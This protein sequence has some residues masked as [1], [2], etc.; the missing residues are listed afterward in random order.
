MRYIMEPFGLALLVEEKA[1]NT[2]GHST[3]HVLRCVSS[4]SWRTFSSSPMW[5]KCSFSG[6]DH[7][8]NIFRACTPIKVHAMCGY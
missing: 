8:L 3:S 5:V 6:K 4:Q 7:I 1:H 2:G